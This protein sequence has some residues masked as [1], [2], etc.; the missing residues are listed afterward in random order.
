[1]RID[2]LDLTRVTFEK[3]DRQLTVSNHFFHSLISYVRFKAY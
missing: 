1:M 2:T 3:G